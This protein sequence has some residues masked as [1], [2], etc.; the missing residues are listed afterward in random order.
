MADGNQEI[1]ISVE[2][3]GIP[4][5]KRMLDAGTRAVKGLIDE[6]GDVGGAAAKMG[7][8]ALAGGKAL[9][10][11]GDQAGSAA[12]GLSGMG[13]EAV[14]TTAKLGLM[15]A[16]MTALSLGVGG[17]VGLL[18]FAAAGAAVASG[19]L[20]VQGAAALAGPAIAAAA[21]G[22]GVFAQATKENNELTKRSVDLSAQMRQLEA[23][24]KGATEEY[25][26]LKAEFDAVNKAYEMSFYGMIRTTR[27]WLEDT[28]AAMSKP[29]FNALKAQLTGLVNAFEDPRVK[30]V[31]DRLAVNVQRGI[32]KVTSAFGQIGLRLDPA[33]LLLKLEKFF[34]KSID[35]LF[36]LTAGF[37]KALPAMM[38]WGKAI[39]TVL[40]ALSGPVGIGLK[41][42]ADGIKQLTLNQEAFAGGAERARQVAEFFG[43]VMAIAGSIVNN[44]V[45]GIAKGLLPTFETLAEKLNLGVESGG[46]FE[47]VLTK[48]G[49]G[50]EKIGTFIGIFVG[51][52]IE[53]GVQI[54]IT[55]EKLGFFNA[56][57]SG[58]AK[59]SEIVTLGVNWLNEKLVA[60]SANGL[61]DTVQKGLEL[62]SALNPLSW[63]FDI[64]K[65]FFTG[66][67]QG[68]IN[69]FNEKFD[70]TVKL[71]D[72]FVPQAIKFAGEVVQGILTFLTEN[73][74]RIADTL[75]QLGKKLVEWV[76]PQI[77]P[78]LESLGKFIG[79]MLGWF[80]ERLPDIISTLGK[81][82]RI[83]WEWV[84]QQMPKW[85][86]EAGKFI[87]GV[88]K[89]ISDQIPFLVEK[90]AE[91]GKLLI[92]WVMRE[93]PN[94]L[95]EAGKFLNGI[96]KW[97]ADK[98]PDIGKQLGEWAEAFTTWIWK[99]LVPQMPGFLS[100]IIGAIM[101][102]AKDAIPT[103]I[104][105]GMD[106]AAGLAKGLYEG[107]KN[108]PV[109][110][111]LLG[112]GEGI[113]QTVTGLGDFFSGT[114]GQNQ[115]NQQKREATTKA[116]NDALREA[117]EK[118]NTG[119]ISYVK[120]TEYK[121]QL[122]RW[123]TAEMNSIPQY[124]FGAPRVP[125]GMSL[126]GENGPE[127]MY[128]PRGGQVLP[129]SIFDLLK[130]M[131]MSGGA[132]RSP[133]PSAGSVYNSYAGN[134]NS[135]VSND[136]R[137]YT[138]NSQQSTGSV[139]GDLR[140]ASMMGL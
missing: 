75:L 104:Q 92:E 87:G 85:L 80:V 106:L 7:L 83:L 125:G 43:Q 120:F 74:P 113:V 124:R 111:G 110:G 24:G 10:G 122:D 89:W 116:Y 84:M 34:A 81:W 41:L 100:K 86:E 114:A 115:Q 140:I 95:T 50:A 77:P 105:I 54:G 58:I 27:T 71:F 138:I 70:N 6:M 78:L 103:L 69:A 97:V 98:A 118:L 117:Q 49:A 35:G 131:E 94:W 53:L 99:D 42:F 65:G 1:S 112:L 4:N 51:K 23:A 36:D 102:F 109:L 121:G 3:H 129:N 20:A 128:L 91:W 82:G 22:F 5:F 123:L 44:L 11:M 139:L 88:L 96:L 48:I 47:A 133:F 26:A 64:L 127:L 108:I 17:G 14:A 63:V 9:D 29:L 39:G 16:A 52:I 2:A 76:A 19:L 126:I 59:T 72:E 38:Q 67:T 46:G 132:G 45:A 66:G 79:T 62:V 137:S 32:E 15:T 12:R 130:G 28:S 136:N 13:K 135:S 57:M 119:K 90:L 55:L 31:G 93:L 21:L 25:R 60:L 134:T 40:I 61:S 73:G 30:G 68:G 101:D 18:G 37:I 107:A 33:T 8:A 56:L